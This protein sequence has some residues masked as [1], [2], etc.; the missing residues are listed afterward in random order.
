[1]FFWIVVISSL[2]LLP[3]VCVPNLFL[4]DFNA[5]LSLFSFSNSITRFSY[6]ANP[7]TSRI[8]SRMKAAL[9]DIFLLPSDMLLV[10]RHLHLPYLNI[11]DYMKFDIFYLSFSNI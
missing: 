1:M 5:L 6:G 2:F 8:R 10:E 11:S 3:R 7:V 9:V 4:Q